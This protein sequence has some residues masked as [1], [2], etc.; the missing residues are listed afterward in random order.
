MHKN[1]LKLCIHVKI[2]TFFFVERKNWNEGYGLGRGRFIKKVGEESEQKNVEK[3]R[4]KIIRLK[5]RERK[6]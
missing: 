4:V 2:Q 1:D 5:K 3:K 6:K